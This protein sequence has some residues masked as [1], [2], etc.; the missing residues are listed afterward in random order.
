[1]CGIGQS[2][3]VLAGELLD[4]LGVIFDLLLVGVIGD[5]GF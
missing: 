5:V 2:G 1:V 3:I 4:R